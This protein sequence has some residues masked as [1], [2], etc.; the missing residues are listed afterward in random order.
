MIWLKKHVNL[1]S[2][3]HSDDDSVIYQKG[4]LFFCAK[5]S[6][7]AWYTD[8]SPAGRWPTVCIKKF[9]PQLVCEPSRKKYGAHGTRTHFVKG[10]WRVVA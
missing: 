8:L 1:R 10:G 4:A 6:T 9:V 7:V 3:F 5:D 2:E